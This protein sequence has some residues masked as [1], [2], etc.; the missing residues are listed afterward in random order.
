MR[1]IFNLNL[2]DREARKPSI[3][4]L[5]YGSNIDLDRMESRCPYARLVGTTT[6]PGHRLLFKK[7]KTG[8]YLTIEQDA[9]SCVPAV[10]W[11]LSQYDEALL[12][13]YEGYPKYYYKRYFDLPIWNMKGNR[14][15]GYKKCMAYVMHE[16]R[17]L[18]EPSLEYYGL[19]ERGFQDWG[20]RLDTL[21]DGLSASIGAKKAAEYLEILHEQ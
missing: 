12:N 5:A 11:M 1:E 20:F 15:R 8:S 3:Y 18:G 4:Y 16:N 9:N 7:S 17:L 10:V 19:V 13:K 6:I 21:E 2:G 14:M